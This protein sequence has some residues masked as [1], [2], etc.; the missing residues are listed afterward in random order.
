MPMQSLTWPVAISGAGVAALLSSCTRWWLVGEV[1]GP[2]ATT[3]G[4]VC[5]AVVGATL[6][7]THER[8]RISPSRASIIG[9]VAIGPGAGVIIGLACDRDETIAAA[10]AGLLAS[11]LMVP[12]LFA[13]ARA[14]HRARRSRERSI[15][16]RVDRR[17]PWI[18]TAAALSVASFAATVLA[19][20]YNAY[21]TKRYA[22]LAI[23]P[24]GV[25]IVALGIALGVLLLDT[26]SDRRA[27]RVA[28]TAGLRAT[29]ASAA[30]TRNT[31][32]VGV[33]SHAWTNEPSVES[34]RGRS[35]EEIAILGDTSLAPELTRASLRVSLAICA[36]AAL[37]T[38]FAVSA[39]AGVL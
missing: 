6:S 39:V 31:I 27:R 7:H 11:L 21:W 35:G 15:V 28:S 38:L 22:E 10:F 13:M 29:E 14:G 5:G 32:D 9:V 8:G 25:A 24:T 2:L 36:V 33:G 3:F 37:A 1:H 16:G 19:I 26:F 18:A 4:L 34:Y 23:V 12:V 30:A 17:V 20:T